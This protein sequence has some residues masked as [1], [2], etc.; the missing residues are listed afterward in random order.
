MAIAGSYEVESGYS[1]TLKASI[2]AVA[3][4]GIVL[5]SVLT[6][7]KGVLNFDPETSREEWIGFDRITDNGDGTCTLTP[8]GVTRGLPLTGDTFTGSAS[9]VI[10][11]ANC[12][13]SCSPTASFDATYS[14][15]TNSIKFPI[16][17]QPS[18]SLVIYDNLRVSIERYR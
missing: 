14:F 4:S 6:S 18:E 3:T 15:D 13:N 1:T 2:S 9:R 5:N 11:V 10:Q 16:W 12:N 7:T 17:L 8:A